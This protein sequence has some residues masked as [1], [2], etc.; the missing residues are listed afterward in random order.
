MMR[1]IVPGETYWPSIDAKVTTKWIPLYNDGKLPKKNMILILKD[2]NKKKSFWY[3][4]WNDDEETCQIYFSN[5]ESPEMKSE[6]PIGNENQPEF[7][8][9]YDSL[10]KF[11][12][13]YTMSADEWSNLVYEWC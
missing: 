7:K 10:I 8:L 3:A 1:L 5:D 13:D 12:I 11:F 2:E 6:I 9:I 4:G